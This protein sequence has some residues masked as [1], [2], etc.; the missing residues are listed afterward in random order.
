ML[1][2]K[3]KAKQEGF[4]GGCNWREKLFTPLILLC[5][6]IIIICILVMDGLVKLCGRK[7][8]MV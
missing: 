8:A 7:G 2:S 1:K 3:T 6:G 5:L 4:W